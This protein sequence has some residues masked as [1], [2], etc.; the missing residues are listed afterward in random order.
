M[1]TFTEPFD[2]VERLH[3]EVGSEGLSEARLAGLSFGYAQLGY[4]SAHLWTSMHEG[5]SARGLI[6]AQRLVNEDEASPVGL[7]NR[8]YVEALTGLHQD[9]L[10]DLEEAKARRER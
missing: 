5:L 4:M 8:A 9:A 10:D 2:A 3:A 6:Y 1:W 7:W